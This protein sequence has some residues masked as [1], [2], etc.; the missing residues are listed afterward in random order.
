MWFLALYQIS[1][2]HNVSILTIVLTFQIKLGSL[3]LLELTTIKEFK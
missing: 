2:I 3:I 1:D